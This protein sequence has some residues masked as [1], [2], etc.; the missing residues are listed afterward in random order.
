MKVKIL[1]ANSSDPRALVQVIQSNS[2]KGC[3]KDLK[4]LVRV[5]DIREWQIQAL[6][7]DG[8]TTD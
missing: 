7:R 5:Q 8:L 1:S 2:Y 3:E 6:K 4:G